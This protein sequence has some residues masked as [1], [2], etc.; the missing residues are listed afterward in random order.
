MTTKMIKPGRIRRCEICGKLFEAR[1]YNQRFCYDEECKA[2]ASRIR[3]ERKKAVEKEKRKNKFDTNAK[4]FETIKDAVENAR[5]LGLS[6][7]KY[8][9]LKKE[10]MI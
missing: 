6:Y 9:A 4:S 5:S 1:T 7:G 8:V 3:D 10:N 2:E